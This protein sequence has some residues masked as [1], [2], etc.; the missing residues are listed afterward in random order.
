MGNQFVHEFTFHG[1]ST[2][3]SG[4]NYMN[5]M[6]IPSG[7]YILVSGPKI[8]PHGA[9]SIGKRVYSLLMSCRL[10]KNILSITE[11]YIILIVAS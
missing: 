10:H 4:S 5:N 9:C 2:K 3:S 6:A 7:S 1:N 11:L 8:V